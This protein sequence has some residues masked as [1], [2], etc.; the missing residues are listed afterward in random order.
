M[1]PGYPVVLHPRGWPVLVV[2]GNREAERVVQAF[3][4]CAACVTV[5][6]PALTLGLRR[7]AEGGHIRWLSRPFAA[8]DLSGVRVV[9]VTE[10][11]TSLGRRIGEQAQALG[12]LVYVSRCPAWG[13]LSL[14]ALV[15][16]GPLTIAVAGKDLPVRLVQRVQSGIASL[17]GPEWGEFAL[18]LQGLWRRVQRGQWPREVLEDMVDSDVPD[19]LAAGRRAEVFRRLRELVRTM[20]RTRREGRL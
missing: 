11:D 4:R 13:N 19:L 15:Q 3:A 5:V 2:G 8:E 9:V 14:P 20:R 1:S 17:Y 12:I 18:L 6:A 10:A 7:M 16:R